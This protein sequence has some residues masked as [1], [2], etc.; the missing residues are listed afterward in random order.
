M[1][2]K[3]KKKK[4]GPKTVDAVFLGYVE[5][6]YAL[7][8]MVIKS[9]ISGIEVN[10]IV[11]FRDVFFIEDVFPMETGIPSNV[12]LDDSLAATSILE[13]MEKMTNVGLNPNSISLTH[14][15]SN[16]PRWTDVYVVF[17]SKEESI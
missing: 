1:V 10:T 3:H 4:L 8:F 17:L 12:S 14:E 16:E 9:E 15:E 13:H 2:P 11:E 6:S 7:R 5:T